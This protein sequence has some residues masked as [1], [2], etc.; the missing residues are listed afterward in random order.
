MMH[1]QEFQIANLEYLQRREW[2]ANTEVK[3]EEGFESV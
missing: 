3:F 1:L 2:H